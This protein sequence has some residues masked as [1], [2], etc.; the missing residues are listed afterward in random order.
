MAVA[1]AKAQP[2]KRMVI[3]FELASGCL[4]T[5]SVALPVAKPMDNPA[6][7]H[8]NAAIAAPNATIIFSPFC[9][10]ATYFTATYTTPLYST[11]SAI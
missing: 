10:S 11:A 3:I 9:R 5:A 6:P 2:S 1:S 7:R 4:A 8:A